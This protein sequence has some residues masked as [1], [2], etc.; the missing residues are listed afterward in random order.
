MSQ[1]S[2]DRE[3]LREILQRYFEYKIE[4]RAY[5]ALQQHTAVRQ[6]DPVALNRFLDELQSE[7]DKV[8]VETEGIQEALRDRLAAGDDAAFLRVLDAEFPR[9][10]NL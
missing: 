3:L 6:R 1:I 4:A 2:I 5:L 9:Q 7:K 10:T 8:L